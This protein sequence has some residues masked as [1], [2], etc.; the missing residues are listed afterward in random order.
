VELAG[1]DGDVE[2]AGEILREL[3]KEVRG[4]LDT[5]PVVLIDDQKPGRHRLKLASPGVGI[6]ENA[7]SLPEEPTGALITL[8]AAG[9]PKHHLIITGTG[10]AATTFLVQLLTEL[11]LDTG[12]TSDSGVLPNCDAGLEWDIRHPDA[13]YVVKSPWLCDHLDEVLAHGHVAIDH[14]VVPVRD[15][16]A[17]AESRRDVSRRTDPDAF[18]P[19]AVPGG[20]WLTDE[21]DEQESILT[22]KLYE[23]IV[24]LARHEIPVTLL[25]FPRLVQD[26]EYLYRRTRFA[27]GDVGYSGFAEAFRRTSR[28]E[29]VHDFESGS[30]RSSASASPGAQV[31]SLDAVRRRELVPRRGA[32][33]GRQ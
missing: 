3:R 7:A 31:T 33:T 19:E 5:R 11:R 30:T 25:M 9:M 26:P 6:V 27:L 28:P 15:L 22:H 18:A 20:L 13:P 1:D 32:A 29:L 24:A 8:F 16:F 2:L 10:R 12:F 17:A 4:R 21:P 23:L 14:A